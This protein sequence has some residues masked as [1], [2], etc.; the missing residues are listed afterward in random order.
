MNVAQFL[1]FSG[2]NMRESDHVL[3]A[4]SALPYLCVHRELPR[5]FHSWR[6]QY[7]D[8]QPK[9]ADQSSQS[10]DVFLLRKTDALFLWRLQFNPT[11]RSLSMIFPRPS[12]ASERETWSR[13]RTKSSE[14]WLRETSR[15][16]SIAARWVDRGD[17]LSALGFHGTPAI[18]EDHMLHRLR[19]AGGG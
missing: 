1:C 4:V 5:L 14:C 6:A 7:S 18:A 2:D 3:P 10:T 13:P 17:S 16:R 15:P 8:P 12:K 19:G 9:A 11:T